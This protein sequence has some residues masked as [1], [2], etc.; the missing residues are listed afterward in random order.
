MHIP[1]QVQGIKLPACKRDKAAREHPD[2]GRLRD[3]GD[4]LSSALR[5]SKAPDNTS[6]NVCPAAL[7][8]WKEKRLV[9]N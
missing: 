2:P 7:D 8:S 9:T 6:W 4:L 3:L 5:L 1:F